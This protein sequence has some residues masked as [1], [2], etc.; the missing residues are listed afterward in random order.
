M[1]KS[2]FPK[3]VWFLCSVM[4]WIIV[5]LLLWF[6]GG[7][8]WGEYLGFAAGYAE[9]AKV[10]GIS[11]FW[12]ASALWFYLW[13]VAAVGL[14]WAFWQWLAPHPWSKWS[15]LGSAL[16]LFNIWFGVQISVAVNAWYVP[17][18]NLIQEML[19]NKG[20]SI[21]ALYAQTLTF[22]YIAMA[23]V[24]VGVANAFFVSHWVFRWRTAMNDYYIGHWQKLRLVEGA[25][26][27]VQEDSMRFA[28]IME[29]LGVELI[30][31]VMTL[32]AFLPLLFL[33]SKQVPELPIVGPLEHS[34]V[35][36]AIVWSALGTLLLMVVGVKLPGLQFNNQKVEAAYRKELVYGEDFSDRAQP[37]TVKEI[38]SRVR[39]NYFRLYFHYAYFNMVAIWYAQLDLLFGLVILFPAIAA[40]LLSLGLIQQIL[41]IFDKVRHSFQYLVGSWKSIIEM[42][43]IY[44]RLKAFESI[45]YQKDE[46]L[47]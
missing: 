20:G 8:A 47:K 37:A 1:F 24:T 43:S 33:L 41:G 7:R 30:K 6:T 15:I 4:L 3:P 12:Q 21:T 27:R 34:L 25:S 22:L 38:Y 19:S 17:F 5:N 28:T 40:G 2:F 35:W 46:Q 32:I 10:V 45:L 14:F 26:Q 39:H 31:A 23:S 42:L 18:W 36:A 9:Q 11:C 44:K 13:F 29:D 16:I